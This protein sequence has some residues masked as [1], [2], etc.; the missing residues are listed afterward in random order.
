MH[1][2]RVQQLDELPLLHVANQS[3]SATIALQGAQVLCFQRN[4]SPHPPIWLSDL[5]AYRQGQSIRGGIPVCWPWFGDLAH[6]PQAVRQQFPVDNAPAHGLVRGLNWQLETI[7][8]SDTSTVITLR[9]PTAEIGLAH[10]ALQLEITVADTLQLRLQTTSRGDSDFHFTQALHTYFTIGDIH[11]VAVHGL[12]RGRYIETLQGWIEKQQDGAVTFTGE[13]DRIYLDTPPRIDIA[14]PVWQRRI[15]LQAEGSRSAV[16]WNPWI[17]KSKRLS[18][19]A[20]KAWRQM[21]C[22]ET[23]NVL[24]DH[25]CLTPGSSHAIDMTITEISL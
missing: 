6:N 7:A 12:N 23:A 4:D 2:V 18:Q 17:E 10:I 13:T 1:F 11:K 25:V 9:C 20:P 15:T 22:I 3:A 21:L 16:V 19:F 14:D 8:E 5:A 24:D